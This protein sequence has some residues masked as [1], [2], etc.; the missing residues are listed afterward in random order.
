M[1]D[2]R[3]FHVVVG[4]DDAVMRAVVVW[5]VVLVGIAMTYPIEATARSKPPLSSKS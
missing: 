4:E 2:A 5:L 3:E 1:K